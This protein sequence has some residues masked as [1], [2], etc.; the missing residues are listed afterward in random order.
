MET[1]EF[2]K[3][4]IFNFNDSIEYSNSAIVS[5]TV[6]KQNSGNISLFAF[7]KGETISEHTADFDALVQVIDGKG[8]VIINKQSFIITAGQCIIMPAN[9]PHSVKAL[10]K[11]KMLLT[12]IKG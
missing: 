4:N 7:D 9:I 3:S 11:F 5:K 8:E 12:M 2:S 10:E 6:I 1:K